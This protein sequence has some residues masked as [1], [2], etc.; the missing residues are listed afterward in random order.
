ML[1]CTKSFFIICT[2]FSLIIFLPGAFFTLYGGPNGFAYEEYYIYIILFFGFLNIL[3]SILLVGLK[4]F[5]LFDGERSRLFWTLILL[6]AVFSLLMVTFVYPAIYMVVLKH[7][8]F[9]HGTGAILGILGF[10]LIVP[11]ILFLE[12]V[13]KA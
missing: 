11:L 7:T 8:P 2:A 12:K 6:S 4:Y 5:R 1:R 3:F 9:G 10:P 13:T